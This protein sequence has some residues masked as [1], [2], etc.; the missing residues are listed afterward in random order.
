MHA[1]WSAATA[2]LL[3]RRQEEVQNVDAWYGFAIPVL[4]ILGISMILHGLYDT[5]LKRDLGV[6]A[7]AVAVVSFVW[8][9]WL[10]EWGQ[11]RQAELIAHA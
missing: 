2:V 7:L 10:Y 1:A 9:F 3:W 5:L 6:P 8:F 11:R 4:K